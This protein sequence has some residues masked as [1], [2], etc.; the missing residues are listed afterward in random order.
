MNGNLTGELSSDFTYAPVVSL[1]FIQILFLLAA[2][3]QLEVLMVDISCAFLQS[4]CKEKIYT[5]DGKEWGEDEGKIL[6]LLKA[7]YGLKSC[8]SA[9]YE[10]FA[11]ALISLGFVPS[12]ASPCVFIRRHQDSYKYIVCY[13]DD[14]LVFSRRAK[15]VIDSINELYNTKGE[16]FPTYFLGGDIL[17]TK[18]SMDDGTTKPSYA[19]SAKTYIN[20]LVPRVEKI[21]GSFQHHM[22][23]MDPSYKPES[24]NTD[25]LVGEDISVYRMM[26]GSAMWAVTL[27]CYDIQ[28]AT[29]SLA[30]YSHA[31]REGHY[32]AAV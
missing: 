27:G 30:R 31:S 1:E 14:C 17:K 12:N 25:L 15:E 29:I 11:T 10:E 4:N 2:M 22:F 24:D 8:G 19:L 20:A 23:P 9:W 7:V 32:K 26:V 21:I 13:V 5:V 16:G 28:Y 18:I 6:V 3:N